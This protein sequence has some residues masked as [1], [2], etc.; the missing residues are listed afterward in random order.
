MRSNTRKWKERIMA[1]ALALTLVFGSA[2]PQGAAVAKAAGTVEQTFVVQDDN[3][4]DITSEVGFEI[5]RKDNNE[6][7]DSVKDTPNVFELTEG[8][9]YSYKIYGATYGTETGEI[10]VDSSRTEKKVTL[11]KSTISIGSDLS[12]E[13]N[14]EQT[15]NAV[16]TNPGESSDIA[17][18]S[19]DESIAKV[20]NGV[21]TAIYPGST[22][23][24]AIY[25]GVS[26]TVTVA[27]KKATVEGVRLNVSPTSGSNK[28]SIICT[29]TGYPKDSTVNGMLVFEVEG[30]RVEVI[31]DPSGTT[32]WTYD[33]QSIMQGIKT[34]K[35][36]YAENNKYEKSNEASQTTDKF[37][38]IKEIEFEGGIDYKST[39]E[40]A[41]EK[42]FLIPVAEES[43]AERKLSYVSNASE[44]AE[45]S[46]TG[47]VTLKKPGKAVITVK[48]EEGDT[49]YAEATKDFTV[50][51]QKVIDAEDSSLKWNETSKIYDGS[52]NVSLELSLEDNSIVGLM[53]GK[54][55][56]TAQ[57]ENPDIG[58]W[59]ATLTDK[60]PSFSCDE[61]IT[62]NDFEKLVVIENQNKAE[63]Q[64]KV[65]ITE[66]TV[67]IGTDGCED[68]ITLQYGQNLEEAVKAIDAKNHLHILTDV[69]DGEENTGVVGEDKINLDEIKLC[70]KLADGVNSKNVSLKIYKKVLTTNLP[71]SGQQQGNYI[72]KN[73]TEEFWGD[74]EVVQEKLTL[75]EILQKVRFNNSLTQGIYHPKEDSE[76]IYIRGNNE[77]RFS[78]G[79]KSAATLKATIGEEDAGY[80]NS[81]IYKVEGKEYD[82]TKGFT[83]EDGITSYSGSLILKR[84]DNVATAEAKTFKV[85]VDKE[86]PEVAL[87]EWEEKQKV[88]SDWGQAITF[89]HFSK[90]YYTLSKVSVNDLPNKDSSGM[91]AANRG[92]WSYAI[93]RKDDSLEEIT[94][95]YIKGN[96][97][98]F[99][100]KSMKLETELETKF[101]SVDI[102][103]VEEEKGELE[104]LQGYYVVLIKANDNVGNAVVYTSNG[105]VVDVQLPSV[106]IT[107]ENGNMFTKD[108]VYSG[109][110]VKYKIQATDGKGPNKVTSGLKEIRVAINNGKPEPI[111]L[112]SKDNSYSIQQL[113]NQSYDKIHKIATEDNNSNNVNISVT[114]IDRSGNEYTA[115]QSLMID[116][117]KPQ[118]TVEFDN[119]GVAN[120]KYFNAGRIM[121]ITFKERNFDE[122]KVLFRVGSETD[123]K[124]VGD[125]QE[126]G[127]TP[128]WIMDT[129]A[130]MKPESYTDDRIVKLQLT[131][132]QEK[133]YDI[134]LASCEDKA[135]NITKSVSYAEETKAKK[136]FVIDKTP[137]V[138]S[139]V[140]YSAG[141]QEFKASADKELSSYSDS[142]SNKDV[143]ATIRIKEKNFRKPDKDKEFIFGE[144]QMD[145]DA[146]VGTEYKE[147]TTLTYKCSKEKAKQAGKWEVKE[148]VYECTLTFPVGA[149]QNDLDGEDAQT[150]SKGEDA[151]Y[152]FG[153]TYKDLAGNEAVYQPEYFTVDNDLPTGEMTVDTVP[154]WQKVLSAIT[155][156]IFKNKDC[157]VI[158]TGA[159]TTAGVDKIYYHKAST[160]LTQDAFDN[161]KDTDWHEWIEKDP[162]S[163][164]P[165]SE[166]VVYEKI[167]DKAG[168]V[169]YRYPSKWIVTENTKPIINVTI[170]NAGDAKNGV[171]NEN[172]KVR[173]NV[174][175]GNKEDIYS[176]LKQVSYKIVSGGNTIAEEADVLLQNNVTTGKG[177]Q[178]Y[179]GDFTIY[180]EKFNSNDVNVYVY[181]EDLSGNTAENKAYTGANALKIDKTP[182]VVESF[183]WNTNAA[184]N[185]KYY[186]TTRTATITVRERNFDE[187]QVRLNLTNTDGTMPQISNW[188]VDKSGTS[189]E[190]LNICTVTFAA[191]GDYTMS[192]SCTDLAG[193]TSNTVTENE[194]TIDKTV[195]RLNVSFD[196]NSVKN[197]KYYDAARTATITVDEHNFN[198][199]DV[200]TAITSSTVTPGVHGWSNSGNSHSA[201]VPFT[202][203][204][205]YSFTVNYTDLAG[206]PA[207]AY[208]V[209]EFTIDQT[210]PEVEIFDIEDKSANN[211]EVAPG[212]R[213]SDTNHD[214]NGVS[215]TYSGAKHAEQEVDGARSAIPNGESIKMAD[216]EHTP[217]TDDVYTMVA[218]VTDLAGNS[219]EK[220]V[221]FSVNRFGSNFLFSEDTEKFLDDYYN[222]EE[223]ELV[224]TEINVDTLTHRGITCGH[225][226]D[227]EDF[228]EGTEYTV[229]ESG[230]EVSW[231]SYEYTIK[232]N[233]F[234][235]EGMYNITIDSVD[236]ATNQVNNKIKEA[237]IEFVIDKTA[238]TVV[239]N[240][241]ED[242]GQYRTSE[243]DITIATADNMAMDRVELYVDDEKD[244]AESYNAKTIQREGGELPYTLNSSS[245]WQEVKAVAIDK[246]GNVTDTSRPEDGDKEK[247]L[248]VL[249]TS[250][251]FVQFYRNTPLVIGSV[252]GLAALIGIIFLILAKRRK[253]EES[254]EE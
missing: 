180:A 80:Y 13:V 195:P 55:T 252:V 31:A 66:R 15:L 107:D 96:I 77:D 78:N 184:S 226:G 225:D 200:N 94:A 76:K 4:R 176:G 111:N 161:L 210:K 207:Q 39:R 109:E 17:W 6:K 160:P 146:L 101:K 51:Y 203:D 119:N 84:D 112:D 7:I 198:G 246:A 227:T 235:K 29:V 130:K 52:Q 87:G 219:D 38:E 44:V 206:N 171:F 65:T 88:T 135:G 21:V 194:F 185:G 187:N 48:A 10:I 106:S 221:T 91:D 92:A 177:E 114:A 120:E 153:F 165:N 202:A 62:A 25:N 97:T 63:I 115:K 248:S 218:K 89:N 72:L 33:S 151:N 54:L 82:L 238:P 23:I 71:E 53:N 123:L 250:N 27:V 98:S 162:L 249:V 11:Q 236:R 197:G 243:R 64:G 222:N 144:G 14:T 172:V 214:V 196:N 79:E 190:N 234:E 26:A 216:F 166:T 86:S 217:E 127:I 193:N 205:D 118:V 178:E 204:G 122:D 139:P 183:K 150:D 175:D 117:T 75:E 36:Y 242:K 19:Q 181:A 140:E 42:T 148:D 141:G 49:I 209:D 244:P 70:L 213:Y 154:I 179:N 34:I 155:F 201:T 168:N 41:K 121:T 1:L 212:V 99:E 126:Y 18:V 188:T 169:A 231:K 85:Y 83:P 134:E 224:V 157:E 167:V 191:D 211:G 3:N 239:I 95:D 174:V 5:K 20:N 131:F 58:S 100:W 61:G 50:Y 57:T 233:N 223:E 229:K 104:E 133:E 56:F 113:Q 220:T 124:K 24:T 9:T 30:N 129:E 116:V 12:L 16:T 40:D 182:P 145:F 164:S 8:D 143:N 253:Q 28:T 247:W 138:I 232:K 46:E 199:S 73:A 142:C 22:Q 93:V 32:E 132:D 2:L 149:A 137:P 37:T 237:D 152:Q 103:I 110:E 215:I 159:D 192:M 136:N 163:I 67:Y 69:E 240:G 147:G 60:A 241:I 170:E 43:I 251:V 208:N 128:N 59:A 125:L 230:T 102:P 47:E 186:N 74:L 158:M 90:S 173:V 108:K 245:D 45:V 254:I 68:G 81:L 105:L 228:K 156:G 189:D 35:V